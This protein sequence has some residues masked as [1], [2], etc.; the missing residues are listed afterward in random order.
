MIF[1]ASFRLLNISG[2]N[3]LAT[4][5]SRLKELLNATESLLP[6]SHRKIRREMTLRQQLE[7][8]ASVSA[9]QAIKQHI[10]AC[11]YEGSH[12]DLRDLQHVAI[13]AEELNGDYSGSAAAAIT[14]AAVGKPTFKNTNAGDSINKRRDDYKNKQ[15]KHR[16]TVFNK[17]RMGLEGQGESQVDSSTPMQDVET[18]KEPQTEKKAPNNERRP[19]HF[20]KPPRDEQHV[21]RD[22]RDED[23]RERGPRRER[24]SDHKGRGNDDDDRQI[25]RRGDQGKEVV[26]QRRPTSRNRSNRDSQKSDYY[27]NEYNTENRYKKKGGYQN[28]WQNNRDPADY[29]PG[30]GQPPKQKQS[31]RSPFPNEEGRQIQ[32][33]RQNQ[34]NTGGYRNQRGPWNRVNNR[35]FQNWNPNSHPNFHPSLIASRSTINYGP[36]GGYTIFPEEINQ[37]QTGT[38]PYH[39]NKPIQGPQGFQSYQQQ[40]NAVQGHPE[41]TQGQITH[42]QDPMGEAGIQAHTIRMDVERGMNSTQGQRNQVNY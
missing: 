15:R 12:P 13:E 18:S 1:S 9:K 6:S 38:S 34:N 23:R 29:R 20:Q 36:G 26:I 10:S 33:E 37:R 27:K 17:R 16:D 40:H 4:A 42:A 14:T 21:Q 5:M 31:W 39:Q 32:T 8:I 7:K 24:R 25:R 35:G 11:M 30:P 19:P 28:N 41:T 22:R 2:H 3:P